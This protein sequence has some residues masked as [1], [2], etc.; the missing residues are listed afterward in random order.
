MNIQC[1]IVTSYSQSMLNMVKVN[2][3]KISRHNL[4]QLYFE[5]S[6]LFLSISHSRNFLIFMLI[7]LNSRP[8]YFQL[9]TSEF[10]YQLETSTWLTQKHRESSISNTE[11]IISPL[12][13]TLLLVASIL[14]NNSTCYPDL[15]S[16]SSQSTSPILTLDN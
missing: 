15:S 2:R 7:A 1:I 13:H 16:T 4:I 10:N 11:L 12:Q 8:G 5:T 6:H 14:V 3:I 9:Q